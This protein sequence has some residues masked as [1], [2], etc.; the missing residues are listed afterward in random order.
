MYNRRF[1][2]I[3]LVSVVSSLILIVE[4]VLSHDFDYR[5]GRKLNDEVNFEDTKQKTKRKLLFANDEIL[6]TTGKG[7]F[8]RKSIK[9]S[10]HGGIL[11]QM[12]LDNQYQ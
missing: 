5:E 3:S 7:P 10:I 1:L 2:S 11:S 8:R 9:S 6:R 12:R 4:R